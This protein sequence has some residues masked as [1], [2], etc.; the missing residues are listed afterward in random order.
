[1]SVVDELRAAGCVFA[2]DEARLLQAASH[3][4]DELT[5]LVAR[6]VAGEPL[7]YILGWV[8]FCGLRLA[9]GPGVFVPRQR[10]QVLARQAAAFCGAGAVVVDL[11]CGCGAVAASVRAAV[12]DADVH[13]ADVD[14]VAVA[15]AQR[16]LGAQVYLG[17]LYAALPP[18]LRGR[19]DVLT[20]NAPY[21]P[22]EAIATMP[23]EA[24]LHEPQVA[25][26]GGPDG[27]DVLRRVIA[28]APDW[29]APGA[30]LLVESSRHQAQALVADMTR[31]ALVAT[32]VSDESATVVVA[33]FRRPA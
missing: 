23:P 11:C 16:N 15:Y 21:V 32:V 1:M 18:D 5:A 24:R 4:S 33:E 6:R 3:T 22:S 12:P 25:L 14:P 2:E 27:L 10:T 13:A 9:V 28:G 26:D 8:Q 31:R 7:E 17:D 19:I 20:A 29:L 30:H